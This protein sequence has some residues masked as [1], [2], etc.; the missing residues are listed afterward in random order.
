MLQKIFGDGGRFGAVATL[1]ILAAVAVALGSA[2][3]QASPVG[4]K[5]AV[6]AGDCFAQFKCNWQ[7]DGQ[8][9][10][11]AGNGAPVV[12]APPGWK[13]KSYALSHAHAR[14]MV[15]GVVF[16]LYDDGPAAIAVRTDA[17]AS[18]QAPIAPNKPVPTVFFGDNRY[19]YYVETVNPGESANFRI[20]RT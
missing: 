9:V 4:E 17:D 18:L 11:Q 7:A 1:A 16:G 20:C 19:A 12:V 5:R 2:L 13:C 10:A 14:V 15:K 3:A 8:Q 6:I